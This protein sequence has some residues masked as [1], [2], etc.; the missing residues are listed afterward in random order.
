[1]FEFHGWAVVCVDDHP[2]SESKMAVIRGAVAATRSELSIAEVSTPGNGLTVLYVHG[3]R[4]HRVP[5]IQRLFDVVSEQAPQSYGLLY[6]RDEE[7]PRGLEFENTFRVWRLAGG[8]SSRP[9]TRSS[10]RACQRSNR[11]RSC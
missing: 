4:N 1:M 9:L 2:N 11:P 3:R 7:D 8:G 10:L 6:I 5:S